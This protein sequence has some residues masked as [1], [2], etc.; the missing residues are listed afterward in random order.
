[1]SSA[2]AVIFDFGNVVAFPVAPEKIARAASDCGLSIDR[3]QQ[4]FWAPRLDYDAGLLDAPAY[5]NAVASEADTRFD[6]ALLPTL[7]RHEIEFWNDFDPRVL[8][9]IDALRAYGIRTGI[10]S[11]LPRVLGEALRSIPGFVERFDHVTF[12]YELRIVKPAPAIYH[13]AVEGLNIAPGEALFLDDKQANV[14]GALAAGLRAELF[15]TW[16]DFVERDLAGRYGLPPVLLDS[17]VQ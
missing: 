3:F 13:H 2:R 4:A 12:S 14:D 6:P 11:N 9:W 7:I 5:W 17:R 16:E 1:M 8:G 10:L 15:T